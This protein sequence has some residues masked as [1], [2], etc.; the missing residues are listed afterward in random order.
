MKWKWQYRNIKI[1]NWQMHILIIV[2]NKYNVII[3]IINIKTFK[4]KWK[5]HIKIKASKL[6]L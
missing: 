5:Q 4:L 3:Y 1:N 6:F 2:I